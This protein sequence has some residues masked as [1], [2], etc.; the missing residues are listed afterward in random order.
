MKFIFCFLIFSYLSSATVCNFSMLSHRSTQEHTKLFK[1]F[2]EDLSENQVLTHDDLIDLL[3]A[4]EE[5]EELINPFMHKNVS[6]E[7]EK[8]GEIFQEY[9]DE[10]ELDFQ[11][12]E[13]WLKKKLKVQD[14]IIVEQKAVVK[15][16]AYLYEPVELVQVEVQEYVVNVPGKAYRRVELTNN[17]EIMTTPVTQKMF[18]ERMGYNPSS[19]TKDDPRV[20]EYQIEADQLPVDS[21][22]IIEAM[23]FANKIS[24]ENGYTPVYQFGFQYEK[25]TNGSP[26]IKTGWKEVNYSLNEEK[27]NQVNQDYYSQMGYRIPTYAEYEYLLYLQGVESS[28]F[29]NGSLM[30]H[31]YPFANFSP[32]AWLDNVALKKPLKLEKGGIYDLIGTVSEFVWDSPMEEIKRKPL[33]ETRNSLSRKLGKNLIGPSELRLPVGVD[34]LIYGTKGFD[35]TQSLSKEKIGSHIGSIPQFHEEDNKYSTLR[36]YPSS[37]P[38]HPYKCMGNSGKGFRLIRTLPK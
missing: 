26:V 23:Q 36:C 35:L 17:F 7:N 8:Y 20:L 19:F 25:N 14:K 21:V 9:I 31:S 38:L 34:P 37:D 28:L 15:E 30:D 13:E 24:K 2:V 5:E 10:A 32:P 3:K 11:D 1:F 4:V 18:E 33:F 6:V 22:N 12:I 29:M 16:T 27:Y